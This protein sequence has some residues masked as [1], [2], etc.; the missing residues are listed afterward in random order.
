MVM[1]LFIKKAALFIFFN[2]I[3][4]SCLLVIFGKFIPDR[5]QRNLITENKQRGDFLYNRINDIKNYR[6]VD[7]LFIGS[8]HAYRGFD[9]RIFAQYGYNCFN[10]G[11]TGQTPVQSEMLLKSYLKALNPKI[12]VL[13][14][15]PLSFQSDGIEADVDFLLSL[16][17]SRFYTF[18]MLN[19]YSSIKVINTALYQL[20]FNPIANKNKMI[21]HNKNNQYIKGGYVETNRKFNNTMINLYVNNRWSPK[22]KQKTALENIIQF[23]KRHKVQLIMVQSPVRKQFYHYVKNRSEIDNYFKTQG[24]YYNFNEIIKLKDTVDFIDS[25]HLSQS[26]VEIFNR[27]FIKVCLKSKNNL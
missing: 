7:I 22:E 19:N 14:V 27:A 21:S 12:V 20:F 6:N 17:T 9:V 15:F 11:S 16:P 1:K 23:L 4:Y 2:I 26:G 25:H 18:R 5:Y 13:E 10:L 3:M 8:S 24:T